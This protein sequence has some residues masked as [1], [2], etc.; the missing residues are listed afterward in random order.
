MLR[1]KPIDPK[2]T[3]LNIV[4]RYI[5]ME[6][7]LKADN[8]VGRFIPYSKYVNSMMK[9]LVVFES[10]EEARDRAERLARSSDSNFYVCMLDPICITKNEVFTTTMLKE[11]TD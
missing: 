2:H 3:P 8:L 9:A 1:R 4:P 11:S 5:I 6:D 7:T 10:A